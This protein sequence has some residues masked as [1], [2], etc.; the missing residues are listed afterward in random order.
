MSG[1]IN[2]RKRL[3]EKVRYIGESCAALDANGI[4]LCVG[5]IEEGPQKGWL[6]IIN[7]F[8]EDYVYAPERFEKVC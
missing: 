3:L 6:Y 7:K 5:E 4:Y 1:P 2:K 8:G